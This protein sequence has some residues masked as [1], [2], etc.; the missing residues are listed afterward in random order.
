MARVAQHPAHEPHIGKMGQALRAA[1]AFVEHILSF[2]K[3]A[4][5]RRRADAFRNGGIKSMQAV[6]E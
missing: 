3:E 6:Q 2:N 5:L 4:E 1:V